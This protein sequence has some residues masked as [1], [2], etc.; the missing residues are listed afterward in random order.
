MHLYFQN[1]VFNYQIRA[2]TYRM[3][4]Y[5]WVIM[6]KKARNPFPGLSYKHLRL[7]QLQINI[8]QFIPGQSVNI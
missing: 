6:L 7:I 8:R 4:N 3:T 2:F 5:D 1:N